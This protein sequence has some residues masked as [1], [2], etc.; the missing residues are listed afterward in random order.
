MTQVG[1]RHDTLTGTPQGGI[2]S[3]L[4]AN[5][6][7]SVLDE[8]FDAQWRSEMS[9]WRRRAT[10]NRRGEAN[11]RLVRYAD[12]FVVVVNGQRHH[13]DALRETVAAV[14]APMGLRLAP[15]KTRVVDIDE[16]FR[17]PRLPDPT[18][19]EARDHEG[20]RLHRAVTGGGPAHQEPGVGCDLQINPQPGPGS[21]ATAAEPDAGWV[22][23]LLP[24]RSVEEHVHRDRL[25]RVE[26]NRGLASTQTSHQPARTTPVLRPGLEI[27][28]QGDRVHRRRQRPGGP[29]PLPRS[30]DHEPMGTETAARAGLI[31]GHGTGRAGCGESRTSGSAGGLGKR[32]ASDPGTAPQDDPTDGGRWA[33]ARPDR[34]TR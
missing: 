29:L 21:A 24:P 6:A 34:R 28:L 7:L 5:I 23:E 17:V 15:D 10:R 27:R 12:D 2:L 22:G 4:L 26:P 25:A 3:P 18:E 16:G 30:E 13:A 20:L 19:T 32:T 14:L 11:W 9:T 33:A 1:E 31:T 8:H